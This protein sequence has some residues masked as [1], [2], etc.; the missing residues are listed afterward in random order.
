MASI[1]R[2]LRDFRARASGTLILFRG[3]QMP[4]RVEPTNSA[5]VG[6]RN[7]AGQATLGAFVAEF[8]EHV[9]IFS[10]FLFAPYTQDA[11]PD[12]KE[13]LPWHGEDWTITR[14]TNDDAN[15]QT[16][17]ILCYAFRDVLNPVL[18]TDQQAA[19]AAGL[20]AQEQQWPPPPA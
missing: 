6:T 10:P 7:V 5:N 11:P 16:L 3:K 12:E 2:Q 17:N 4:A 1:A 19:T 13:I 20:A 8:D 9:F 14:V 15:G 18:T